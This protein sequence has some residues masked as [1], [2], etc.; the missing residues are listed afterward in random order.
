M[1]RNWCQSAQ[2]FRR[3]K[4]IVFLLMSHLKK[5]GFFLMNNFPTSSQ[6]FE[7]QVSNIFPNFSCTSV[8]KSPSNCGKKRD[9]RAGLE[10][11][12]PLFGQLCT[13]FWADVFF[14]LESCARHF[15]KLCEGMSGRCW[16]LVFPFG[17]WSWSDAHILCRTCAHLVFAT[18]P[19][20][21]P[22]YQL[23]KSW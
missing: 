3:I 18:F 16:E 8:Q 17:L 10:F 7:K 15:G 6:I 12:C 1:R 23:T 20:R 2:H 9:F 21:T 19:G 13:S 11:S 14:T 5:I 22:Y 4:N